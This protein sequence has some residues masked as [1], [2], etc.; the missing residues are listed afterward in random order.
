MLSIFSC[1]FDH[2]CVFFGECSFRSSAHFLIGLFFFFDIELHGL[3]VYFGEWIPCWLLHLQMFSPIM[4][5]SFHFVYGF[6]CCAETP[7]V[8]LVLTLPIK[9]SHTKLINTQVLVRRPLCFGDNPLNSH[10]THLYLLLLL[11]AHCSA[12]T[13]I[14][15]SSLDMSISF[16]IWHFSYVAPFT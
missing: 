14:S 2:L 6:L 8:F 7:F 4:W 13:I 3:F 15:S 16:H 11:F 5:V 9:L 1:T 10:L 12:T